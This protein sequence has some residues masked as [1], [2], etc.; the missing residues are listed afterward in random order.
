M[1]WSTC[2]GGSTIEFSTDLQATK[3]TYDKNNHI[4]FAGGSTS[5]G[6]S[7]SNVFQET[8][9]DS[10]SIIA[11]F[12]LDGNRIWCTYFAIGNRNI[13]AI[14]AND[15][16]VYVSGTS[17][18]CPPSGSYNTYYGTANG[19]KPLPSNCVDIYLNKFDAATGQRSWGTYYGGINGERVTR[20]SIALVKDKVF[21][22]GGSP[23]YLNQEIATIGS[24]QSNSIGN[25]GFIAQFNEDGSRN[26][27]TYTGNQTSLPA[28]SGLLATTAN[29]FIDDNGDYYCY[30][31][32]QDIDL[33]TEDAYKPSL[34]ANLHPDAYVVKFDGVTNQRIW[35][36][37]YGGTDI[38]EEVSFRTYGDASNFYIA[39]NTWS[40]EQIATANSLQPT[41]ILL[42]PTYNGGWAGNI[43]ITHFQPSALSV[44]GFNDNLVSIFPNH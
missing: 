11:K 4:Y 27:G 2:Y 14:A 10:H 38:E 44:T 36:T 16:G 30:S 18:D 25:G 41:K 26:W 31:A 37:Y 6:L 43:F 9:G 24:Y 35:G 13:R 8:P 32:T 39:C 29:I 12:D 3:I 23:N 7:T 28:S 40:T 33:V 17:L 20:K 42:N 21:L 22:S 5:P 1:V 19:F 34:G 15:L